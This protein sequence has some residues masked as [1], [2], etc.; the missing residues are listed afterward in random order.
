[1]SFCSIQPLR[2]W[3]K[4]KK[5]STST[6][7]SCQWQRASLFQRNRRKLVTITSANTWNT[8]CLTKSKRWKTVQNTQPTRS[9][10]PLDWVSTGLLSEWRTKNQNWYRKRD[11]LK[12]GMRSIFGNKMD[13][14]INILYVFDLKDWRISKKKDLNQSN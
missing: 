7:P 12:I 11:D 1:M 6:C 2:S 8:L 13:K 3:T 5:I 14:F 4:R 9:Q 10:T